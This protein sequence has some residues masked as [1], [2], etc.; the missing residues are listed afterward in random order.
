MNLARVLDTAL[1]DVPPLR[2]RQGF[3]RM[4]P[5]HVVREHIERDGPLKMV[6][7]PD[8]NMFFRLSPFQYTLATLFNGERS[9]AEVGAELTRVTGYTLTEA[10]LVEFTE[11]LD[12]CDFWYRTPQEKSVLLCE[13]LVEERQKKI[14][15]KKHNFGDLSII[16]VVY[17]DPDKFL[18]WAHSKLKFIYTPRFTLWTAFMM[19]VMILIL[20]TR[21]SEVWAD[22]VAFYNFTGKGLSDVVEFFAVFLLLGAFHETAHG[23]TCIHYGGGSHRMG[24]FLMYLVPGV[25]CEVQ[26]VFVYGGRKA[27]MLTVAAGVMSEII[28]CQYFSVIWWLTPPGTWI[29]NFCYKLILS[30]GILCV[31]INWNPLSKMDGYYLFC[32]MF[33]FWDL[34]GLSSTFLSAWVRKNIFGLPATVPVLPRARQIGFAAYA[35]LSGVYCY[36]LMLFFVRVLYKIAHHFSPQW[37]FVPAGILAFAIF[38][39]RLRKLGQFMKEIYLDKNELL[40]KHRL[41]FWATAAVVLILLLL[42]LWRE[43]VEVPFVLEAAERAV[44]RVEV[45]GAVES[46]SVEEG[47]RVE[48]GQTI[49][50]LQDLRLQSSAAEAGARYRQASARA[51]EAELSYEDFAN[52]E[53]LRKAT[54]VAD[55]LKRAELQKLRITSPIRGAV[56]SS[57]VHDLLG[58]YLTAGTVV[59]EIVN[60]STMRARVYI[61]EPDLHNLAEVYGAS[62]RVKSRWQSFEGK[63]L[64]VSPTSRD[65]APGLMPVAEYSGMQ[66]PTYF[67]V[68]L[69][70]PNK[71]GE[72]HEGMSG[73]AKIYG[74][75]RS[76]ASMIFRP[77]LEAVARR[78]W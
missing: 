72:L 77:I 35:I 11:S 62:L 23:M 57:R 65:V 48:A 15:K 18:R 37:A 70:V 66:A 4:H 60:T 12:K 27:R 39:S 69:S 45:P 47:Q 51:T 61:S 34:K 9:Y 53:Q 19:V 76:I 33:R 56:A 13:Q 30:G 10:Q 5:Q 78:A 63:Y 49:A 54:Q 40:F 1:P 41:L 58:S 43:H 2:Q 68:D 31:L 50:Q 67:T 8:N 29:H 52:A 25:F 28:L 74:P 38:R 71:D 59:A 42:P 16:E 75:R 22:S 24:F 26:E 36:S 32:E 17:F 46:V 14:N 44:V 6:L 64:G 20:G 3:P 73:I 7:V 55:Q 21:W